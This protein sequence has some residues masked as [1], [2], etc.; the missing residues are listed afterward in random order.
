ME[1]IVEDCVFW[2]NT[3]L[4]RVITEQNPPSFLGPNYP[5]TNTSQHFPKASGKRRHKITADEHIF[6]PGPRLRRFSRALTTWLATLILLVPVVV[7]YSISSSAARLVGV[8]LSAGFFLS[9]V[10][11][12]TNART[13]ELFAAGAR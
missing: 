13:V 6:L 7:L 10:S 1:S 4:R 5:L 3:R 11:L 8:V 2:L 9:A 12:F